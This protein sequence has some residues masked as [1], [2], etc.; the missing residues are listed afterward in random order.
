AGQPMAADMVGAD[1][2]GLQL[3]VHAIGDKA[4]ATVLDMFAEVERRNGAR[5][6]RLRIEHAQHLRPADITRFHTRGVIASMQ[7]YHAIDDGRW[8]EKRISAERANGTYL[9]RS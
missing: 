1:A 9:F 8:A 4:N 7:P 5:D 3:V 6:R 2:A